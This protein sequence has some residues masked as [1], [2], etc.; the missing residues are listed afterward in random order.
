MSEAPVARVPGGFPKHQ[1]LAFSSDP[2]WN[3]FAI[4][5]VPV[6]LCFL[7][8]SCPL[9]LFPS[10]VQSQVERLR[11]AAQVGQQPK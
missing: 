5:F 8:S 3:C 6:V 1:C 10:N 2:T 11:K 7:W 4:E 9:A